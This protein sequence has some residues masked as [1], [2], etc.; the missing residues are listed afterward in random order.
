[1]PPDRYV[2][3]R[4]CG[5]RRRWGRAAQGR[6]LHR[7]A[8]LFGYETQP[9]MQIVHTNE[10]PPGEGVLKNNSFRV[11]SSC[12]FC[13]GFHPLSTFSAFKP[14]RSES[15]KPTFGIGRSGPVA[16]CPPPLAGP[17]RPRCRGRG[18]TQAPTTS[19]CGAGLPV[20]PP[21]PLRLIDNGVGVEGMEARRSDPWGRGGTTSTN[22]YG[23][24]CYALLI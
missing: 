18:G 2:C 7:L 3:L 5:H 21:R 16:R 6:L 14:S 15:V 24:C 1:M 23:Y 17:G 22:V 19:C 12:V 9:Q 11:Q 4:P 8:I 10:L 20:G 13:R